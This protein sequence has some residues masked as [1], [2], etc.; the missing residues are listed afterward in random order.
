MSKLIRKKKREEKDEPDVSSVTPKELRAEMDEILEQ[1]GASRS[2]ADLDKTKKILERA[3]SLS[4][5]LVSMRDED[6]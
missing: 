5:E 2:Q 4:D 3:G 6:R 1:Y